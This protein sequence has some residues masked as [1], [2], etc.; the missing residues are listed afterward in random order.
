MFTNFVVNAT[1]RILHDK[2]LP[3]AMYLEDS[4]GTLS[5][6]L[7]YANESGTLYV[8]QS[9]M[10]RFTIDFN[11][12]SWTST[13]ENNIKLF[14]VNT[15]DIMDKI[16]EISNIDISG[17]IEFHEIRPDI[18][19]TVN[20]PYII[21]SIEL[22]PYNETWVMY[23]LNRWLGKRYVDCHITVKEVLPTKPK[24]EL[25]IINSDDVIINNVGT[26]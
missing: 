8:H 22:H 23:F 10:I 17:V 20:N 2:N 26:G 15:D 4:N 19:Y 7:S 6:K 1:D 12:A 3:F 14:F 18:E 5:S 21:T 24:E 13:L 25:E 11:S 16:K 9:S